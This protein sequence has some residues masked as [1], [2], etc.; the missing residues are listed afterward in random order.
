VSGET[1]V[2]PDIVGR[3]HDRVENVEEVDER[4]C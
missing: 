4:N 3:Y 2:G 1:R